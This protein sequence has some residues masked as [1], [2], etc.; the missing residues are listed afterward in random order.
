MRFSNSF[1]F[2]ALSIL[3]VFNSSC[4]K[5]DKKEDPTPAPVGYGKVSLEFD[6]VIGDQDLALGTWYINGNGDSVKLS[7][8]KYFVTNIR[9]GKSDGSFYTIPKERSY[10]MVNQDS[11]KTKSIELDSIPTGNYTTVEFLLGVD[12]LKSRA[13]LSQRTGVLDPTGGMTNGMYWSWNSGY[14]FFKME[15]TS[16]KAPISQFTNERSFFYHIGFYGYKGADADFPDAQAL[17][18]LKTIPLSK[19]GAVLDVRIG[20]TSEAHVMLDLAKVWKSS[21]YTINVATDPDLMFDA[22]SLKVS[23]N[24][25]QA[26][27]LDHVH[28]D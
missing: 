19:E 18:N 7:T 20:K 4:K 2:L 9:L 1:Y 24:Y 27:S 14:I 5:E 3:L 15:G 16:P 17:N 22:R 26:F 23:Q 13:P 11:A 6:H 12:S 10:F 28:N 21:S 25:S 8:L